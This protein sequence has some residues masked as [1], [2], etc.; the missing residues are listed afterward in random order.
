M[1]QQVLGEVELILLRRDSRDFS[2]SSLSPHQ[3]A[4]CPNQSCATDSFFWERTGRRESCLWAGHWGHVWAGRFMH[5]SNCFL[6]GL[7]VTK[8]QVM[9]DM[10]LPGWAIMWPTLHNAA[11]FEWL[12]SLG[13]RTGCFC[14]LLSSAAR[15]A[16]KRGYVL[17]WTFIL[18]ENYKGNEST[19]P[20]LKSGGFDLSYLTTSLRGNFTW[21]SP[22]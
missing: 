10:L 14:F 16:S 9:A 5:T 4:P 3:R 18:K 7:E 22:L 13:G 1:R 21:V 12:R 15:I 11:E 2:L 19:W 17:G 8:F 20:Q 6:N